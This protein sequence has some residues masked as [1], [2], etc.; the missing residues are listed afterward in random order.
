MKPLIKTEIENVTLQIENAIR[1]KNV[2][3][4]S[5][6]DEYFQPLTKKEK[7]AALKELNKLKYITKREDSF[8]YEEKERVEEYSE[9]EIFNSLIKP[10]YIDTKKNEIQVGNKYYQGLF[11]T[12]FPN[13]VAENW[14]SRLVNEK[15]NVDFSLHITPGNIAALEIHLNNELK[16]INADLYHYNLRG[17]PA[18][19]LEERKREILQALTAIIQGQYKL[20]ATS[21]Y[22]TAK[23]TEIDKVLALGKSVQ[24]FLRAE[25]IES[26]LARFYQQEI[27][28]STMPGG[29]DLLKNKDIN[30][31]D[32]ALAASF[33]FSSSFLDVDEKDGVLLG[34]N[35]RGLPVARS[36]WKEKSYSY[37]ILGSTGSG[38]SYSSKFLLLNEKMIN[39]TRILIVDPQNE[40]GRLCKTV[41][42]NQ[43]TISRRSKTIPN[44]LGL[45][46]GDFIEK[47]ISLGKI[48]GLLLGGEDGCVTEA[49]KPLLEKSILDCY[50]GKGIYRDNQKTWHKL[51]PILGDLE[52]VMR[53]NMHQSVDSRTKGSYEILLNRLS[54]FTSGIYSFLNQHGGELDMKPEFVT[55]DISNVP[56]EVKPVMMLTILEYIK[57]RMLEMRDKKILCIDEAHL[58][59][60]N[61]AISSYIEDLIRTVRKFNGGIMLVTQTV[62][63]L[64]SCVE[65]KAVL[66]NS[67]AKYIFAT[68][69]IYLDETAKLFNLNDVEKNLIGTATVGKGIL[70]WGNQH[71]LINIHVDPV[72]HQL[73]TTKPEEVA[74]F[75]AREEEAAPEREKEEA[76]EYGETRYREKDLKKKGLFH[77]KELKQHGYE[78][79]YDPVFSKGRGELVWVKPQH[80]ESPEHTCMVYNIVQEAKKLVGTKKIGITAPTTK[81]ADVIITY[82]G[83]KFALE[84]E[85]GTSKPKEIEAKVSRH[86]KEF[87]DNWCFV[88]IKQGKTDKRGLLKN[89]RKYKQYYENS[90]GRQPVPK[91]IREMLKE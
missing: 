22:L 82:K 65:G 51:P 64:M 9:E 20:Y 89:I 6:L 77:E 14:L 23:G 35:D 30:I 69:P 46:G 85:T 29:R 62:G 58:L 71:F 63:E 78:K 28:K 18:P 75:E 52:K 68:E 48:F 91:Y 44:L 12:G 59:L 49:Q 61:P 54:R 5:E 32:D 15:E 66:A 43:L 40:Y 42:G 87:G 39:D 34:F 16:R 8:H 38:K 57:Q 73:I 80:K 31:P 72:T 33:P 7:K 50:A 37:L 36:I 90:I 67:F 60:K 86:T 25:A 45:Y 3:F 88:V 26:E 83:K 10:E 24:S 74:E 1:K 11:A 55:F 13:V 41:G 27:L 21:L 47:L 53:H 79:I 70:A 19:S 4:F 56:S 84:V 76:P 81:E 17:I 2:V